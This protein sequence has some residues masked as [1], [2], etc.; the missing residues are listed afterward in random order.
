[1][2][3]R[4]ERPA[5]H[6][7]TEEILRHLE[8]LSARIDPIAAD[9]QRRARLFDDLHEEMRSR[10]AEF[11]FRVQKPLF[12]DLILFHDVLTRLVRRWD[13]DEPLRA[14]LEHARDELLEI[15]YRHDI[16]RIDARPKKLDVEVQRPIRRIDTSDPAEDR[17]VVEYVHDGFVRHDTVLRPQGIVVKR[18]VEEGKPVAVEAGRGPDDVGTLEG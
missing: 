14:D 6:D 15:L 16:E 8:A 7:G 10:S 11:L 9:A 17:D 18:F 2:T 3:D 5:G 4:G 1:M 12:M 13:G